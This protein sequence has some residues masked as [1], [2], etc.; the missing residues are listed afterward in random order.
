VLAALIN[1]LR[2]VGKRA[3]DVTVVVVG[4]GAAGVACTEIMLAHGVGDVVVCNRRGASTPAPG[5]STPNGR[6]SP[7]A[8]T[9]AAYAARP[10][11]C[12]PT[13]TC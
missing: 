11:R 3:E 4:A 5:T 8:R 10:T 12:S 7:S 9:G 1:A 2:V 6:G 13:P